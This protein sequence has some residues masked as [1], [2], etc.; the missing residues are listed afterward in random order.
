MKDTVGLAKTSIS[1]KRTGIG[2]AAKT[3]SMDLCSMFG[4]ALVLSNI[5]Y[6]NDKYFLFSTMYNMAIHFWSKEKKN[7]TLLGV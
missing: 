5:Y 4:I 6:L 3:R 2:S 7:P 1:P